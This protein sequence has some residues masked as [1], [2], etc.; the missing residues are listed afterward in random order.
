VGVINPGPR[1]AGATLARYVEDQR[2]RGDPVNDAPVSSG[3]F[4]FSRT[5]Q[6]SWKCNRQW[7]GL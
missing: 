2:P 5:L 6:S 1:H 3:I 7:T 4:I